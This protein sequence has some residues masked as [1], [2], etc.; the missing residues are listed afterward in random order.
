M[1]HMTALVLCHVHS[2]PA[3]AHYG[4]LLS[5]H[6][7]HVGLMDMLCAVRSDRA[8]QQHARGR[9]DAGDAHRPAHPAPSAFTSQCEPLKALILKGACVTVH[10]IVVR[11]DVKTTCNVV[12]ALTYACR[13]QCSPCIG[14]LV[15]D[16]PDHAL[17]R[18]AAA[19]VRRLPVMDV[20]QFD[21]SFLT[22]S[23]LR[24]NSARL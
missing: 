17:L 5:I 9:E 8:L 3:L 7:W 4:V 21:S 19:L 11:Q 10:I 22:V 6:A 18:Q 20:K 12:F 24:C 1:R 23:L 14:C 16:Q 15:G 13:Q 2:Q